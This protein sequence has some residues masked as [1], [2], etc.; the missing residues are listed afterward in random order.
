M[1]NGATDDQRLKPLSFYWFYLFNWFGWSYWFDSFEPIK[2]FL[3]QA[4]R[5]SSN[6]A[7]S[8]SVTEGTQPFALSALR[9]AS[10]N[11]S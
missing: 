2:T 11:F 10:F 7:Q 8:F 4:H 3:P 5:S 6:E 9:Y 1:E